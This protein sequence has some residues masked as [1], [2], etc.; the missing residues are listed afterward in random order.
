MGIRASYA[1]D[2]A[3]TVNYWLVNGVNQTE[4]FNAH[5]DQLVG[6]V[7][8]PVA[9]LS[10]TFN[11]YFG[12]EHPDV[13]YATSPPV[14]P[15]GLPNQQ[16]VTVVPIAN[17]PDGAL[18]IAD[19]YLTWQASPALTLAAEADYV[20]E[21][22]YTYSTPAHVAGGALYAGYKLSPQW[23]VAARAEYLADR[24]GLFSGASQYLKEGTLTLDYRPAD[25]F[26][27]RTEYRRDQSNQPYFLG[28]TL[29]TLEPAQPTVT[30]GLVWWFGQK[31]GAW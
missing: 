24:G 21:R 9:S 13:V 17:A 1:L 7:L 31:Q 22:L 14:N 5:K 29:A 25:G 20:E 3:L 30:L 23:S 4:D 8:T 15:Q 26:L 16:G 19:S 2:D 11:Y 27:M 18:R 12:R 6:F 10:W 28:H